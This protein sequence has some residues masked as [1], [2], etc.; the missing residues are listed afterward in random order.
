MRWLDVA[1][2]P[3]SGKSHMCDA[4]WPRKLPWDGLPPPEGW[5][6][7]VECAQRLSAKDAQCSEIVQRYIRKA[8]TLYRSAAAGTYRNTVLAQAGLEIGWRG[9][10]AADYFS[11]MPVSAGV[12]FLWAEKETLK[13][14]NVARGRDRSHMVDGMERT[15]ILAGEILVSRGVQVTHINTGT[16]Q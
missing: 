6:G 7:F 2:A 9:H 8:S 3:A 13:R 12:V 15:R 4:E 10:G 16:A 14:R 1:G 5:A 11:L